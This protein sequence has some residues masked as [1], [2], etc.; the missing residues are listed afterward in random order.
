MAKLRHGLIPGTDDLACD[1]GITA[2]PPGTRHVAAAVTVLAR[3]W[4]RPDLDMR[5]IS[6]ADGRARPAVAGPRS[7]TLLSPV[8]GG[9]GPSS[10]AVPF[11]AGAV[12]A[13]FGGAP[14]RPV[15]VSSAGEHARAHA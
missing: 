9:L 5:P 1:D 2:R 12:R 7:R 6:T 15:R 4:H 11:V 13:V 14:T 3:R 8:A 10:E